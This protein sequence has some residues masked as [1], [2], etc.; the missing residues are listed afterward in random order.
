[1]KLVI[2]GNYQQFKLYLHLT[3]QREGVD[4]KYIDRPEQLTGIA[5]VTIVLL[6]THNDSPIYIPNVWNVVDLIHHL[7]EHDNCTVE[8]YSLDEHVRQSHN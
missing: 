4:A 6:E 5:N 1:M 8:N 7:V 3:N 2:A